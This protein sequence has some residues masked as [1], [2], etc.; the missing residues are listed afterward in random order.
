MS[1]TVQIENSSTGEAGTNNDAQDEATSLRTTTMKEQ[2]KKNPSGRR[3]GAG[4]REKKEQ[5]FRQKVG[6]KQM[7]DA[8]AEKYKKYG[9]Q[10]PETSRLKEQLST[11]EVSTVR[12]PIPLTTSTRGAGI[13]VAI[14]YH[15][16]IS[17]FGVKQIWE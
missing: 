14:D 5:S 11:I 2:K 17:S 4:A 7:A 9:I 12:A 6:N 13:A 3:P 8:V 1:A 15:R 10:V 16:A